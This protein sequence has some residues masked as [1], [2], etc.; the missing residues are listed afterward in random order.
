MSY[1]SRPLQGTLT[2][3]RGEGN[4]GDEEHECDQSSVDKILEGGN[5]NTSSAYQ[6]RRCVSRG[7]HRHLVFDLISIPQI[8]AVSVEVTVLR[9]DIE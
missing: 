6:Q 2:V 9:K 1:H 8:P 5:R 4:G 7:S 3:I